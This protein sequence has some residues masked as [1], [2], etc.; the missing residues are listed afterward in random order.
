MKFD[1]ILICSDHDGTFASNGEVLPENKKAIEYFQNNGGF[2]TVATGRR[3][4]FIRERYEEIIKPHVPLILANGTML[5]NL[6]DDRLIDTDFLSKGDYDIVFDA[7]NHADGGKNLRIEFEDDTA[8]LKIGES[9]QDTIKT[10]LDNRPISK[11]VIDFDNPEDTL[12]LQDYLLNKYESKYTIVRAWPTGLEIFS[13]T[14]GKDRY[15]VKVKEIIENAYNVKINTVI[16]IGDYEND[17]PLIK[18]ADVGIA[19]G[20]APDNV[21]EHADIIIGNCDEN[22]FAEYIYSL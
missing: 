11:F 13:K 16:G 18:A 10:T 21:K 2:F 9:D 7:F 19:M 15:I 3:S 20:N 8:W 4:N 5:Y 1:G 12:K 14:S 6:T 22:G 17:I